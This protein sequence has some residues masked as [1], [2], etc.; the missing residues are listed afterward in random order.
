MANTISVGSI[1]WYARTY[2][3]VALKFINVN[4]ANI[5]VFS[6]QTYVIFTPKYGAWFY[7]YETA[8]NM[9]FDKNMD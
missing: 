1:A 8:I 2:Q 5:T 3:V 4:F 9:F 6:K 7:Y